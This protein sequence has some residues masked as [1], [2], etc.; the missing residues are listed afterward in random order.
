MQLNNSSE[1]SDGLILHHSTPEMPKLNE[2]V[3][4][5][6]IDDQTKEFFRRLPVGVRKLHGCK[7]CE[8][9]NTSECPVKGKNYPS[10][11]MCVKRAHYL[12][13]FC[14]PDNNNYST[15]QKN[16]NSAIAQ[17]TN[18]Q[19]YEEY[20]R[21]KEEYELKDK[22]FKLFYSKWKKDYNY[23]DSNKRE[24]DAVLKIESKEL[25]ACKQNYLDARDN[26]FSLWD[27]NM[28]YSEKSLDR[29]SREKT[30]ERIS[31]L[32]LSDINSIMRGDIIDG[33]FKEQ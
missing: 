8:W 27:K 33:D 14:S 10:S 2:F 31:T 9:K 5:D 15:W 18:M 20:L 1:S 19:D 24:L 6:V 32:S 7:G 30:A 13:S 21:K 28:S 29:S 12:A 11:G 26:W 4:G 23:P 22:E 16:Y 17:S 25:S 3:F